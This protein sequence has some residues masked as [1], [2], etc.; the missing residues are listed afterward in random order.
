MFDPTD[1]VHLLP[2]TAS[3]TESEETSRKTIYV[4]LTIEVTRHEAKENLRGGCV[5]A[6][7]P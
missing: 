5:P 4:T 7:E 1:P 6:Q 2:L 3:V